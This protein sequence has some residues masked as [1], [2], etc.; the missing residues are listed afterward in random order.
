MG[1]EMTCDTVEAWVEDLVLSFIKKNADCGDILHNAAINPGHNLHT[2]AG[3][4]G[5]EK[6]KKRAN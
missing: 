1:K 6:K 2:V 5:G 4:G 3:R